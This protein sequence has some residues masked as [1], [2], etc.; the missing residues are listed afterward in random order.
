MF[1]WVFSLIFPWLTPHISTSSALSNNSKNDENTTLHAESILLEEF[2]YV[3]VTLYQ[4]KEERSRLFNLYLLIV[5]ILASGLGTI[6]AL[7]PT[8]VITV[9]NQYGYNLQNTQIKDSLVLA[10]VVLIGMSFLSFG[11][12]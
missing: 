8:Q 4:L 3:S 1:K 5:G 10:S 2:N 12:L 6:A 11:F 9:T 7:Y